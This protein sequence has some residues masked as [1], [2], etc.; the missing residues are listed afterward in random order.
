[1]ARPNPWASMAVLVDAESGSAD[2]VVGLDVSDAVAVGGTD[3][4]TVDVRGGC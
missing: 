4:T 1:M 2:V 3:V